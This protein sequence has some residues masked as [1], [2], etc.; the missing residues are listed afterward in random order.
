MNRPK[1]R[2]EI[3]LGI[4]NIPTKKSP[5]LRFCTRKAF[6]GHPSKFTLLPVEM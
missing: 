1:I 6:P 5:V 3:E 2:K 4:K